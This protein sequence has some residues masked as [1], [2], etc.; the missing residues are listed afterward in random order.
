[1]DGSIKGP[2]AFTIKVSPKNWNAPEG[3]LCG[4]PRIKVLLSGLLL[5]FLSCAPSRA[6]SDAALPKVVVAS[7]TAADYSEFNAQVKALERTTCD[8]PSR[9]FEKPMVVENFVGANVRS[10]RVIHFSPQNKPPKSD[11]IRKVV[12]S[13]WQGSLQSASCG[14]LWA[15]GVLWSI[16]CTLEFKDGKR[17]V[18]ITDGVHVALRDHE[19]KNWFF[20]LLPAAQ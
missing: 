20:R 13:V 18:L 9:Y 2:T 4:A 7:A 14:I 17:G 11:E 12:K 16:E 1:M 3:K 6:Y 10:I 8:G 5:L 19:G 15:E